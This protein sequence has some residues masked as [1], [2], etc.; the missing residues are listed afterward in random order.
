MKDNTILGLFLFLLILIMG[1][2][3]QNIYLNHDNDN[4]V[5]DGRKFND[6]DILKIAKNGIPVKFNYDISD[7]KVNKWKDEDYWINE[8]KIE[9]IKNV[10]RSKNKYFTY[11]KDERPLGTIESI[12][13]I[14]DKYHTESIPKMKMKDFFNELNTKNTDIIDSGNYYYYY[15]EHISKISTLLEEDMEEIYPLFIVNENDNLLYKP[16]MLLWMGSKNAVTRLHYDWNYNFHLVI[17]GSK[18][19]MFLPPDEFNNVYIFP[20]LHPYNT[21]SQ[22]FIDHHQY[23][24]TSKDHYDLE[25]HDLDHMID[26][27]YKNYKKSKFIEI[28]VNEGQILYIPPLY[29]HHVESLE[30][31]IS[32]AM[33]SLCYETDLM[34]KVI[35][36][37]LPFHKSWSKQQTIFSTIIYI[38]ELIT[39]VHFLETIHYSNTKIIKDLLARYEPLYDEHPELRPNPIYIKND[40]ASNIENEDSRLICPNDRDIFIKPEVIQLV[41]YFRNHINQELIPLFQ[42]IPVERRNIWLMDLIEVILYNTIDLHITSMLTCIIEIYDNVLQN[43][44]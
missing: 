44:Y 40:S 13:N 24:N 4:S 30:N 23:W 43:Q 21:K 2:L 33:W 19:F 29:L 22:L 42:P 25:Y 12:K 10:G 26:R 32:I 36:T 28:V 27:K 7:L 5:K 11:F 16:K 18:R 3:Y 14:K 34:N 17:K 38:N 20:H 41:E 1:L 15:A 8:L 9:E 37:G 6:L 35:E 31:S 39:N